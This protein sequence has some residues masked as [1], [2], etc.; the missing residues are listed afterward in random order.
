[1]PVQTGKDK[2]GCFARW[3]EQGKKYYYTC[4]DETSRKRAKDKAR[5]QGQAIKAKGG[6]DA[7]N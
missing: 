5:K 2:D 1:M 7:T 4:K 6:D 3:G